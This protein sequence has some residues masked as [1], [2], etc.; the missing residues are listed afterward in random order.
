MSSRQMLGY[1]AISREFKL[2][3][4]DVNKDKQS[5]ESTDRS[6]LHRKSWILKVLPNTEMVGPEG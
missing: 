1:L 4:K 5:H 2:P 6:L 3:M